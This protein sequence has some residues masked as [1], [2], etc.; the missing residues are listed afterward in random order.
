MGKKIIRKSKNTEST[1]DNLN[2]EELSE[3]SEE[4]AEIV[5]QLISDLPDLPETEQVVKGV[6]LEKILKAINTKYGDNTVITLR[7]KP[8]FVRIPTGVYSVDHIIGGG[9]P[10]QHSS[11]YFGGFSGGKT[12]LALGTVAA[13]QNLCFRCF[14]PTD[15][16]TCSEAS[17]KKDTVWLNPEGTLD[18]IWAI[19]NKVDVERLYLADAYSAEQFV[20]IAVS[21]LEAYDC[22]LVVLDSVGSLLPLAV[23]EADAEQQSMGIEAKLITKLVKKVKQALITQGKDEHA[24]AF[25][26]INQK[27]LDL[28]VKFGNPETTVGG[29]AFKHEQSLMLRCAKHTLQDAEKAYKSKKDEERDAA[30]KH[31][32]SIFKSKLYTLGSST[33]YIRSV[34][35]QHPEWGDM[36]GQIMDFKFLVG[37]AKE[38]GVL[39]DDPKNLTFMGTQYKTQ[40]ELILTLVQDYQAKL[41]LSMLTVQAA[42][43]LKCSS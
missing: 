3:P 24:V 39:G 40:K 4:R 7:D 31:T 2:N 28:K 9:I 38:Y 5:S 14:L 16:C 10:V 18:K 21:S 41:M 8:E 20:D 23:L 1:A 43:E 17:L 12:S 19:T 26:N 34:D 37:K 11:C 35:F 33:T 32:V 13:S 30:T 27:R 29:E 36:S 42:K 22:G 6:S 25:L 15:Y